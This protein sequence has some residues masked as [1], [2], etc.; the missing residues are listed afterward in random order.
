MR[1]VDSF[2][3]TEFDWDEAKRA[4]TL[5]LRG[6]DFQDAAIALM[7]PHIEKRSDKNGEVRSLAVCDATAMI[8]AVVYTPRD[9]KCR[10]ISVR[11]A[12]R[13][14]RKEYRELLGG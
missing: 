9:G 6:I 7:S 1:R 5:K 2:E 11:P 4:R 3:Y 10:I 12:S 8:I 13:Y 14:E